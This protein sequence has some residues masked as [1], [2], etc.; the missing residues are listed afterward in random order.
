MGGG[1]RARLQILEEEFK[2]LAEVVVASKFG[3][4]GSRISQ[5]ADGDE[6]SRQSMSSVTDR[7]S[8]ESK[9]A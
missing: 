3:K 7:N 1:L 9:E 6:R 4:R 5:E 8:L 2:G